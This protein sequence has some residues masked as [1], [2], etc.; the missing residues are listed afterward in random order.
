MTSRLTRSLAALGWVTAASAGLLALAL[1]PALPLLVYLYRFGPAVTS[2]LLFA[3]AAVNVAASLIPLA[4]LLR[5]R[6]VGAVT[7]AEWVAAALAAVFVR[8]VLGRVGG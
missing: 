5:A 6:S 3:E 1:V 7:A 2:S 4:P 8:A